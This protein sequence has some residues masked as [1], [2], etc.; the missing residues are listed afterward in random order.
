V[1]YFTK[2]VE[3]KP[4]TNIKATTIQKLFWQNIICRFGVPRELTVDNGKQLD[5]Y[6]F[7]EYFKS[8]GTHAKFPSVLSAVQR[9]S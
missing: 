5:C 9:S 3:A 8:M 2:S 7:K 4:L 6:T 1:D